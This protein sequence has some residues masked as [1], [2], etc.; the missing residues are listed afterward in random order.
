[1]K[2]YKIKWLIRRHRLERSIERRI[3]KASLKVLCLFL[4]LLAL[5]G[6]GFYKIIK[7]I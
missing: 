1:M 3:T 2:L 5:I 4:A 6:Y 7:M